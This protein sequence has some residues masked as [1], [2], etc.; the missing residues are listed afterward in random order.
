MHFNQNDVQLL[1]ISTSI[2]QIMNTKLTLRLNDELIEH[3]KQYAKLHHTSVSQLVAE[4]FLQLQKIQQQVEHSPLPSITQQ[5][6]GILKEH[7]VTDVK[8]E[9]YD[10][11]EKKYQ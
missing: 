8:T 5:L 7:D 2:G 4:Y 11:L 1:K 3:A 9:Y 10:A 6:S